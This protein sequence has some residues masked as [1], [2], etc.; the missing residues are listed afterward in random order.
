MVAVVSERGA[1][2][3]LVGLVTKIVRVFSETDGGDRI[4]RYFSEAEERKSGRHR[5]ASVWVKRRWTHTPQ[6]HAASKRSAE[7]YAVRQGTLR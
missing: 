6:Q 3:A 1:L 5:T 2:L 4:L 7:P